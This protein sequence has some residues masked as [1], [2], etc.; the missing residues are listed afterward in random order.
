MRFDLFEELT[1]SFTCIG[2]I[3]K[4][5]KDIRVFHKIFTTQECQ[6]CQL[7]FSYDI[8]K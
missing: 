8:G 6:Y 7:H 3:V 4:K 2:K 1:C 5:L